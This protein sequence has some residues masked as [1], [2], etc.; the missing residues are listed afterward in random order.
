MEAYAQV[1]ARSANGFEYRKTSGEYSPNSI[2]PGLIPGKDN[3]G[4]FH[5]NIEWVCFSIRNDQY[6]DDT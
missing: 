2:D 6:G 3:Q 5:D 4:K 1:D